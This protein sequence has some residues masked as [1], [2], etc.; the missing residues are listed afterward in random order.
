MD[1]SLGRRDLLSNLIPDSNWFPENMEEKD[2]D[3]K[4]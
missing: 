2:W 4:S 3:G 1:L